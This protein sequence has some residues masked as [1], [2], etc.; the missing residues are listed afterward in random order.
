MGHARDRARRDDLSSA[1]API[2]SRSWTACSARTATWREFGRS[3][4]AVAC[5]EPSIASAGYTTR[6]DRT[7]GRAASLA[8]PRRAA[9]PR[10]AA[11]ASR[12]RHGPR[13]PLPDLSPRP[14]RFTGSGSE[15]FRIWIV[16]LLLSIAHAGHLLGVGQGAAAALLLRP[17]L[18]RRRR[19]RLSRLADRDP[20]GPADRLR[21]G[22]DA[23]ARQPAG[24]ARGQRALPAAAG[25]D[26]DR[27]HARV[28]LPRR[29]L[30]VSRHPL[31][32]RRRSNATPFACTCCSRCSTLAT[33]ADLS[34]H[35]RPPARVPASTTAA[36]GARRSG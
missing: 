18:G 1:G 14:F 31:R 8:R 4:A 2:G 15:Y 35:R 27:A 30:V 29:Q 21:G 34:V 12:G 26:A 36:S 33:R 25:A 6:H 7:A 3:H 10:C 24:A 19:V 9:A 16:N 17:H 28:P 32:L 13:E 11:P 20:Q 23:G 5:P 22:G